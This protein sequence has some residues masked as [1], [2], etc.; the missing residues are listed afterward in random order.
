MIAQRVDVILLAPR[1]EKPLVPAVMEAKNAG[2]P[3]VPVSIAA[4]DA[5]LASCNW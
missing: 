1:E 4:F 3:L 2:I 5:T